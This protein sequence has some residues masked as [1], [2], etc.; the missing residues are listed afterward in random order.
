[1]QAIL[2][3]LIVSTGFASNP[4]QGAFLKSSN[5]VFDPGPKT[6]EGELNF[7]AEI[8]GGTANKYEL[9]TA[10]GQLFLD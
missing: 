9:R 8:A 3:L 1:M 6:S 5:A 4:N 7:V 10:S 2:A